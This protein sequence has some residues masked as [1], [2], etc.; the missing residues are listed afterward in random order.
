MDTHPSVDDLYVEIQQKHP[1][2]SKATVYRNLS[3]MADKGTVLQIAVPNDVVRYDGRT[4][5]H[6]HFACD[7]CERVYDVH[8][9]GS[10]DFDA[11]GEIVQDKYNHQVNSSA[12]MFFGICADCV[13]GS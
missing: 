1:P 10:N 9:D 12:T 7:M 2:I 4:E 13:A 3:Y 6:H 5:F 11:L 8:I